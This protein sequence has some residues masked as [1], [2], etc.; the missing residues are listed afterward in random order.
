MATSKTTVD[1]S[2][3]PLYDDNDNH[4]ENETSC[5]TTAEEACCSPMYISSELNNRSTG[6]GYRQSIMGL[7]NVDFSKYLI[8]GFTLSKDRISLES[9]TQQYCTD[10]RALIRLVQEQSKLPP[11]PLIRIHGS[12]EDYSYG[13]LEEDFDLWIDMMAF[14]SRPGWN[15]LK[16]VGANVNTQSTNR[17][18][19]LQKDSDN[20]LRGWAQCFVADESEAKR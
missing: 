17:K 10:A 15:Y 5:L 3:P 20:T 13:P 8:P 4:C 18:P 14:V 6:I 9:T 1:D 2:C 19:Q 11:K 7:P 12:H 16:I